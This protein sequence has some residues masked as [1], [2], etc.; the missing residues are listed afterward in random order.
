MPPKGD[1]RGF[2]VFG[3]RKNSQ[4]GGEACAA[5]AASC[6]RLGTAGSFADWMWECG[7]RK[8]KM[9]RPSENQLSDGLPAIFCAPSNT[10]RIRMPQTPV[11]VMMRLAAFYK[12]QQAN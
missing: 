12:H 11:S 2:E 7:I 6:G 9:Q 8:S 4:Q 3:Q 5:W 1:A 10:R